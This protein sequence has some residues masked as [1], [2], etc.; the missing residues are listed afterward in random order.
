MS[1]QYVVSPAVSGPQAAPTSD[2]AELLRQILDVQREQLQ[3]QQRSMAAHDM[4][5]RWRAFIARWQQDFPDLPEA[6][7]HALPILERTYG[8]LV[9]EL[10]DHLRN[11]DVADNEFALGEFLDRY[12]MRLNQLGGLLSLVSFLAEAS[13][14]PSEPSA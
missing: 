6:C 8:S 13:N 14:P 10:S 11:N 7:R 9:G 12:G 3:L 1:F 5:S 4:N 2:T